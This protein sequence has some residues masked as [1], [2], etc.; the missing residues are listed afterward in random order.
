M[1]TLGQAM[2][3]QAIWQ[4]LQINTPWPGVIEHFI[5]KFSV[6]DT[7]YLRNQNGDGHSIF[8]FLLLGVFQG[9]IHRYHCIKANAAVRS[10]INTG[11]CS[12]SLIFNLTSSLSVKKSVTAMDL[13]KCNSEFIFVSFLLFHLTCKQLLFFFKSNGSKIFLLDSIKKTS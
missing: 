1:S 7:I 6:R 5:L 10:L 8:S 13:H 3:F 11:P 12:F 4:N 9:D 2:G